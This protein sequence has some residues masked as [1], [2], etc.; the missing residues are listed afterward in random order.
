MGMLWGLDRRTP[1]TAV[2]PSGVGGFDRSSSW[3]SSSFT[4]GKDAMK[5]AKRSKSPRDKPKPSPPSGRRVRWEEESCRASL[6]S[7]RLA[8][9]DRVGVRYQG[10]DQGEDEIRLP[11]R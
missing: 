5:P 4:H 1:S 7:S 6:H 9:P 8:L 3:I 2:S 11:L 10:K